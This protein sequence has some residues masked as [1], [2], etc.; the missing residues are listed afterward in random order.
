MRDQ[1]GI[2]GEW[3]DRMFAV[4][5]RAR[6]TAAI[7]ANLRGHL[8]DAAIKVSHNY[9]SCCFLGS[10]NP[11]HSS[12]FDRRNL[13]FCSETVHQLRRSRPSWKGNSP[14]YASFCL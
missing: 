10:M 6:A 14:E 1:F 3:E 7:L 9:R 2:P 4:L 5:N 13:H 11:A 12:S 8:T